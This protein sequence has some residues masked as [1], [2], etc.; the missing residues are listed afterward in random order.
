MIMK[1]TTLIFA[2]IGC[3]VGRSLCAQ[4]P[5]N[6]TIV[7]TEFTIIGW[8]GEVPDLAYRQDGK[9]TKLSVPGF[10]RSPVY[11]YTGPA[12]MEF[13]MNKPLAAKT[14]KSD[15]PEVE[16]AVATAQFEPGAKRHTVLLAGQEGHYQARAVV[17]DES[18]FPV[19]HARLFNLCPVR[20]AVRCNQA[21]SI[22]LEPNQNEVVA[23]RAGILLVT[24]T[25]YELNGK[26]NRANDDFVPV[27]A[28]QQTSVFYLISSAKYF[29]TIDG[30]SRQMQMVILRE[31]PGAHENTAPGLA[32]TTRR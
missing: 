21:K 17:D 30:A 25:A 9:L 19:G 1:K 2:L 32:S 31:K 28:D 14:E 10:E 23:P 24:E 7:S 18:K 12:K 13:F 5:E 6:P 4:A 11:K 16:T 29:S 20:V 3:L 27:P 26:W 8:A 15:K 22:V